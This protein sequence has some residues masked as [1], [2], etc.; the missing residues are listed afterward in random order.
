MKK[1]HLKDYHTHIITDTYIDAPRYVPPL[2][3]TA[4]QW[5]RILLLWRIP[6]TSITCVIKSTEKRENH[7]FFVDQK[8]RLLHGTNQSCL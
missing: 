7:I 2:K 4:K 3:N 8:Q 6:A 1:I 5:S